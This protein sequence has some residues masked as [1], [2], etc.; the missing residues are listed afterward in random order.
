M[1]I[2]DLD[3]YLYKIPTLSERD[4]NLIHGVDQISVPGSSVLT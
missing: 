4:L 3:F 1:K 2:L